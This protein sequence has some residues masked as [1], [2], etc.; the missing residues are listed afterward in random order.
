[1]NRDTTLALVVLKSLSKIFRDLDEKYLSIEIGEIDDEYI[2]RIN[3]DSRGLIIQA[4]VQGRSLSKV[5]GDM[6]D[7]AEDFDLLVKGVHT[8]TDELKKIR[9]QE[10]AHLVEQ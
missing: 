4:I 7:L 3:K 9:S 10:Y 5:I 6:R 1:M 8:L 2:L